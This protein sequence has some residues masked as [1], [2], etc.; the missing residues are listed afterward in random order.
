MRAREATARRYA[1]ALH[2][3]T[4][5]A[6]SAPAVGKELEA[7]LGAISGQTEVRDVLTR[8]WIKPADRRGIAVALSQKVGCGKLVQDFVGLVAERG[9]MDHFGEIVAAY[10]ALVDE[11]LGQAR[12][13]VRSAV[14]LTEKEKRQLGARLER[15]VGKRILLEEQVDPTLLGGFVAQVGS[16]ILDGSLDGQLARMRERLARG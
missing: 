11:D 16:L 15:T 4:R 1:K 10:R 13:Q 7:F 8:H 5:E 6:G 9:R 2:M 3:I 12:A 14:A